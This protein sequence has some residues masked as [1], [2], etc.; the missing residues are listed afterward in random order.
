MKTLKIKYPW[1]RLCI[2]GTFFV[3]T[4]RPDE[5][6]REGLQASIGTQ[7]VPAKPMV[8]VQDGKFGVLFRRLK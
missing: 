7:A 8:G 4:L 1:S 5:V 3:P 2:N 6:I